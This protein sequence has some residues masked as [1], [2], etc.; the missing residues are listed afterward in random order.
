MALNTDNMSKVVTV[1]NQIKLKN[2]PTVGEYGDYTFDQT[3]MGDGTTFGE[4]TFD[5]FKLTVDTEQ[6]N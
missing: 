1:N 4:L 2:D 6:K 3:V 5:N